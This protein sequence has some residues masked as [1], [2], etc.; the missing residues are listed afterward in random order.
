MTHLELRNKYGD[1]TKH[2]HY[3]YPSHFF[4]PWDDFTM[5]IPTWELLLHKYVGISNVKFLELGCANGRASYWLCDKI[6]TGENSTLV[7]VDQFETQ[8]Y[9]PKKI[10]IFNCMKK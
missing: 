9:I 7:S 4:S 6:L 8:R 10:G 2:D 3:E 5:H 1:G